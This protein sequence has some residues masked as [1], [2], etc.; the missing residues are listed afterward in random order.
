MGD[1]A[2]L[3][4]EQ[5]GP[6]E[7][8]VDKSIRA[9]ADYKG[10]FKVG[11]IASLFL[12][13]TN[14]DGTPAGLEQIS[15]A[16]YNE[17][18]ELQLRETP[19]SLGIS[20]YV[21]DWAIPVDQTIGEYHVLWEYVADDY[22]KTERQVVN[23]SAEGED[24]I[25]QGTTMVR[26]VALES[27]LACAQAIPIY[28]EQA[29]PSRDMKTFSFSFP[30]WNQTAGIRVYRNEIQV[31]SGL[32]VD[33]FKGTITFDEPLSAYDTI[34][35][36]Y[37][38]RWFDIEKLNLYLENAVLS[39]NQHPPHSTYNLV[40]LPDKYIPAVLYKAATDALRQLM[41]CLQYQQPQQVFGGPE[42]AQKAFS[43]IETLKK[44][45]EEE[46]KLLFEQKKYGPY[47]G[48]TMAV[49]TPEYTLPGGRSRWFRY[50]YKSGV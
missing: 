34:M 46:W 43:N 13:V 29:R 7:E 48:L 5:Y 35:A 28:F 33:Y 19:T 1:D 50:L 14:F 4:T 23:V 47:V 15:I 3:K 44:N 20:N 30:R 31:D 11:S 21:Y 16:I 17:A 40:T 25:Y 12:T 9:T 32:E 24:S 39:L 18:G 22:S 41:L 38:F 8:I 36:D 26:R 45:F 49:S 2:F 10:T 6:F 37:N 27:Y 42:A